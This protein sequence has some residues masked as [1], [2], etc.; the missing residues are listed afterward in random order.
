MSEWTTCDDLDF[1]CRFRL[2][3]TVVVF[4]RFCVLP[5][6]LQ[7]PT[8][9]LR[10]PHRCPISNYV[11]AT[12]WTLP[13]NVRMVVLYKSPP[14]IH[15]PYMY[16]INCAWHSHLI[17]YAV[18]PPSSP[19]VSPALPF[20]LPMGSVPGRWMSPLL[21][22]GPFL[23]SIYSFNNP[24]LSRIHTKYASA[25]EDNEWFSKLC[26]FRHSTKH[27][28]DVYYVTEYETP[29]QDSSTA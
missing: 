18:P 26:T 28:T 1:I 25:F 15:R 6:H 7:D 4:V 27:T 12:T 5:S 19:S 23:C 21:R 9:L 20:S 24:S 2:Y 16:I 8:T 17:A 22:L 14:P 11:H 29:P 3:S 10:V 13:G